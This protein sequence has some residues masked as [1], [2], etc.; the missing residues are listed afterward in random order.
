MT[1]PFGWSKRLLISDWR[2]AETRLVTPLRL[3]FKRLQLVAQSLSL[4]LILILG[5][6][7]SGAGIKCL[8]IESWIVKISRISSH[9]QA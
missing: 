6:S 3:L 2:A 8:S 5:E 7:W 4:A 9:V 1:L